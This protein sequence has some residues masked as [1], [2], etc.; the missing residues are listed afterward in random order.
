MKKNLFIFSGN[1]HLEFAR[2]V[3]KH[4][5]VD[6]IEPDDRDDKGRFITWFSNGE[7]YVCVTRNVRGKHCFVIQSKAPNVSDQVIE[8]IWIIRALKTS[9]AKKVT[10]VMPYMNY[11]RSDKKDRPRA[12]VG[13]KLMCDLL[14]TAGV[15]SVL[16]MDPHFGQIDGFFE[17]Q[18]VGADILWAKATFMKYI[19]ENFDMSNFVVVAP[20]LGESKHVG[21]MASMMKA[22]VALIDKRRDGDN[23]KAI[24][25]AM[26][27]SVE[28]KDC[29]VFDDET[30][31]GETLIQT[32]DFCI[33]KGAKS[34][35]GFITHGV[36]SKPDGVKAI[37]Q[38]RS[39]SKLVITDTIPLQREKLGPKITVISVTE[40]FA[41]AIRTIYEGKSMD[42]FK[43]LQYKSLNL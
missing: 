29:A 16:L 18:K 36:L 37:H 27:G 43:G 33:K 9:Q 8:L 20:D 11:I 31:S 38:S 25:V 26:I 21:P 41:G 23:E 35:T 32:A 4:L 5:E 10:A 28:G 7:V 1:S 19:I 14:Q 17:E 42:A 12:C 34:V 6:L 3:A 22:P 2:Q 15:D 40:F 13:A 30:A 39:L 24:P